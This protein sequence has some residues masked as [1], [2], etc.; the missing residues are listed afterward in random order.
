M[1]KERLSNEIIAQVLTKA[2]S[3]LEKTLRTHQGKIEELTGKPLSID[4]KELK[5][6]K[7]DITL[8]TNEI[9]KVLSDYKNDFKKSASPLK[10]A[11]RILFYT[12]TTVFLLVLGMAI[13]LFFNNSA[14]E[15][16]KLKAQFLDEVFFSGKSAEQNKKAFQQWKNEKEVEKGKITE[17]MR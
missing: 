10:M 9:Q 16:Q 5:E 8:K 2:V 6:V 1:A 3:S 4:V 15:T 17:I 11:N 13:W 14:T 7:S 12:T